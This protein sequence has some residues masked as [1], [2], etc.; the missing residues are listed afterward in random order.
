MKSFFLAV[1]EEVMTMNENGI[2]E[3]PGVG[4]ATAEKLLM[5]GFDNLLSIA[6]ASPGQLVEASGVTEATARKI[7]YAARDKMDMGFE[8]GEDLLRK[9]QEVIRIST[10]SKALDALIGGGFESGSISECFGEFGSSK[11]Q[12]AHV[13]SVRVQLPKDLGGVEGSVIF[14]DGEGTFRPE[15]IIQ[16]AN[17]MGLDANEV[18]K[19]I[20]VARAFNSDHQMLLSEKS[21]EIIKEGIN[22]KPVKLL[23]VDSLTSHFRADFSG[24]GQLA[25]R[26][27][28]LNRHMH[29]LMK[30]ANQYNLCV[31]VTNQV[32]AKP[33]MFFGDPTAAIG[34]NIVGHNCLLEGTL[35]QL[36]DGRIRKIE[37]IYNEEEV[38]SLDLDKGLKT[39]KTNIQTVA[40]K[41]KDNVYHLQ[42]THRISSSGEHRFFTLNNFNIE[43]VRAENLI[44][45]QY[46]AHGFGFEID[47]EIQKLPEIEQPKLITISPEGSRMVMDSLEGTRTEICENLNITPRQFRRVLNQ[48][49]PTSK[50]NIDLLIK[51]G[52]PDDI[53]SCIVECYTNKHRD[54][55]IPKILGK[56]LSQIFG[57]F[58]GDGYPDKRSIAFKD[59]RLEVLEFYR[60]L[61]FDLTK[62]EGIIRK[63]PNK[64]CYELQINNKSLRD[65]FKKTEEDLFDYIGRSPDFCVI[66]FLK[67][68]FDADGSVDNKTGYVSASQKN[69][70]VIM[71]VQLLL[72][73]I[74]IRSKIRKYLHRGNWINQLDIKDN[75]SIRKFF[76]TIGFTANDKQQY[77]GKKL[78]KMRFSQEMTPIRREELKNLIREFGEY[79]SKLLRPRNFEFVGLE[80]L[81]KVVNSLMEMNPGNNEARKKL[82]FLVDFLNSDLRWEK[83]SKI[84]VEET[85]RTFYDFGAED[86]QNYLANGFLVHNS[87]TRIY[88]RKGKKGTR[89]AKLID[90]PYLA[91]GEAIFM[92]TEG[93]L[94][95]V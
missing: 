58:L 70:D 48:G 39:K 50:V 46:I 73:R 17:G 93:G 7:I 1:T 79:P 4:A 63:V 20:K 2:K 88:L 64:N 89:V 94:E 42:T 45:G 60:R 21:E 24:R 5:A 84:M 56:D 13:L 3:L 90:S 16:M 74:G 19:N 49:Y 80:E 35:I 43:E 53:R 28:K 38:L 14:I 69:D 85:E 86:L 44:E 47:G 71:K 32:M 8:S 78:E 15:R 29:T 75:S 22:G 40:V 81:K 66:A 72:D 55:E 68:F 33:D 27:Q 82:N 18:L 54:V 12:I 91:D 77:L 57:Y 41:K 34:G 52:V 6:V 11:S 37:E 25:D 59:E 87:Q 83:I 67:G 51:M 36:P 10:G 31:Y 95:D 9:R 30:L 61:F 76:E 23:I 62:V 92:V 26:Q 65:L